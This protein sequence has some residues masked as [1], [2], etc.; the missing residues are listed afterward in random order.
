MKKGR[1]LIT[2][3]VLQNLSEMF[4][5][6][7]K[8][9]KKSIFLIFQKCKWNYFGI[10]ES[11]NLGFVGKLCCQILEL[12]PQKKLRNPKSIVPNGT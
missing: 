5:E 6:Q 2:H 11:K 4:S 7:Q 12:G 9:P 8:L 1:R 3:L 10:S